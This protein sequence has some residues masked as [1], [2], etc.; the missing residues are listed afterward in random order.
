[1]KLNDKAVNFIRRSQHQVNPDKIYNSVFTIST[2][3][4]FIRFKGVTFSQ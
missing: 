4:Y 1:M 2:F 3:E